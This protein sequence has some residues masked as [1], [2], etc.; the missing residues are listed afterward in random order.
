MSSGTSAGVT[1][2]MSFH[3]GRR[4][5]SVAF[6]SESD[7]GSGTGMSEAESMRYYMVY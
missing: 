3:A 4:T 6:G 5:T 7:V 2:E 1:P